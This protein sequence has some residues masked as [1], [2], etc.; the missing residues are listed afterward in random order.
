VTA[1]EAAEFLGLSISAVYELVYAGRLP[2]F[3][4][5]LKGG[6]TV[7]EESD[8][9][10]YRDSC[11]RLGATAPASS[12][13]ASRFARPQPISKHYPRRRD[14]VMPFDCHNPFAKELETRRPL[15]AGEEHS[16]D[17]SRSTK[18]RPTPRRNPKRR[19]GRLDS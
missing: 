15:A 8:V 9:A 6:R 19:N 2:H 17:D 12:R 10:E 11:R 14:G 1:K 3:R 18:V 16:G 4:P 7:L 5:S 13:D